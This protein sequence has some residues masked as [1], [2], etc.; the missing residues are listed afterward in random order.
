MFDLDKSIADWS[1]NLQ[2]SAFLHD[3]EIEE[4]RDHL[5]CLIDSAKSQDLNDQQAFDFAAKKIGLSHNL[6]VEYLKVGLIERLQRLPK[7]LVIVVLLNIL[8][9]I[10]F[11]P[12]IFF[13]LNKDYYTNTPTQII[14][15]IFIGVITFFLMFKLL[16]LSNAWRKLA[17]FWFWLSLLLFF[18]GSLNLSLLLLFTGGFVEAE[19]YLLSKGEL[20]D[21]DLTYFYLVVV[22]MTALTIWSIR[23]LHKYNFRLLFYTNKITNA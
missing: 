9:N 15:D 14:T 11:I 6:K 4:L 7:D 22:T 13:L 23:V 16:S 5:C 8:T 17:L 12:I 2:K 18:A 21:F 19:K 20:V 1:T 3:K 10:A